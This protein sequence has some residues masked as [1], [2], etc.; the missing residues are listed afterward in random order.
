MGE[1][2]SK[3]CI[4]CKAD[5]TNR[6]NKA[7]QNTKEHIFPKWLLNRY[8]LKKMPI[9]FS[10]LEAETDDNISI[11]LTPPKADRSLA[12][13]GFVLGK[14]CANCNNGW[15]SDL[16]NVTKYDLI[17]LHDGGDAPLIRKNSL[18]I[19]CTKTA[20]ILSEYLQPN[21]G[22]LPNHWADELFKDSKILPQNSAV[23]YKEMPVSRYWFS[24]PSTHE[25]TASSHEEANQ[26][27]KSSA[28]VIFQIG[29]AAFQVIWSDR[30]KRVS[31]HTLDSQLIG[32]SLNVQPKLG[33]SVRSSG[34][35]EDYFVF[36]MSTSLTA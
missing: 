2:V 22:A 26:L 30:A 5:L 1:E 11:Q 9:S 7:N 18:A 14:I 29:H 3:K 23:F 20:F 8:E 33:Q 6:Q 27:W 13:N 10:F 17:N 4:F 15:M 21:V 31:Y 19:W 32:A 36:M 34:V 25:I 12:L 16:E 24:I 35:E 28:K